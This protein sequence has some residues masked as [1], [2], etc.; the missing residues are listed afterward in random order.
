MASD[1]P[2]GIT[3]PAPGLHKEEPELRQEDDIPSSTGDSREPPTDPERR[4]TT[5]QSPPA[6]PPEQEHPKG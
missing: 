3:P 6:A 1:P 5:H 2:T 4:G